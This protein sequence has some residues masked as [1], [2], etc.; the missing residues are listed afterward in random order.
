MRGHTAAKT[1]AAQP[2]PVPQKTHQNPQQPKPTG[3]PRKQPAVADAAA[4]APPQQQQ[5]AVS[6]AGAAADRAASEQ[7]QYQ[8]HLE[9]ASAANAALREKTAASSKQ[10]Q[11]SVVGQWPA[12]LQ[13]P[14]LCVALFVQGMQLLADVIGLILLFSAAVAKTARIYSWLLPALSYIAGLQMEQRLAA[15]CPCSNVLKA[16]CCSALARHLRRLAARGSCD[17]PRV[18]RD[19]LLAGVLLPKFTPWNITVRIFRSACMLRVTLPSPEGPGGVC[20]TRQGQQRNTDQG[21]TPGEWGG[22]A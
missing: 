21:G 18:S 12:S 14:E 17:W 1:P 8:R 16:L 22:G 3:S 4:S 7:Q 19:G 6:S 9:A 20:R 11:A 2:K 13:L 15:C 10:T 5:Q